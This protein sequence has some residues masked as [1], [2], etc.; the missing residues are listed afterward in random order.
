M[1]LILSDKYDTIHIYGFDNLIKGNRLHY[2]E[3]AKIEVCQHSSELEKNFID[4][5]IKLG[6]ICKLE[7][8]N[9]VKA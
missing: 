1:Y 8:S 4:Y 3:Q 2:F 7:N 9:Q 5:Y 6:K